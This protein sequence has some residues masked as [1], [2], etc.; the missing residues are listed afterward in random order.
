MN[1]QDEIEFNTALGRRIATLR[2]SRR[3][4]QG[5]LGLHI[6]VTAQQVHKYETGECRITPEKLGTCANILDVPIGYFFGEG[7]HGELHRYERNIITVAAEVAE[8]PKQVR[9]DMYQLARSINAQCN[10]SA[11]QNKSA[12]S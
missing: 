12:A 10:D 4:S 5:F 7:K 2:Q 8:L 3:V 6:G 9:K 11:V 1:K